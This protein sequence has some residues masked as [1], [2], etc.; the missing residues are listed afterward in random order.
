M[1]ATNDETCGGRQRSTQN[2]LLVSCRMRTRLSLVRCVEKHRFYSEAET[3]CNDLEE[4]KKEKKKGGNGIRHQAQQKKLLLAP[5]QND[6]SELRA[7]VD[8]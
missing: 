3:D 8:E 7:E 6:A 4:G 2:Y 5:T 1:T